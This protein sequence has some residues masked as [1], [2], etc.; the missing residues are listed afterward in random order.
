MTST[1]QEKNIE[2]STT[3]QLNKMESPFLSQNDK[4]KDDSEI[5]KSKIVTNTDAMVDTSLSSKETSDTA[6]KKKRIADT[7]LTK[8]DVDRDGDDECDSSEEQITRGFEKASEQVL[9]TRRLARASNRW[10]KASKPKGDAKKES[11]EVKEESNNKVESDKNAD[12]NTSDLKVD[13]GSVSTKANPFGS[14]SF[15]ASTSQLK[16]TLQVGTETTSVKDP[17]DKQNSN[18]FLSPPLLPVSTT[19]PFA[20]ATSKKNG[21]PTTDIKSNHV[22]DAKNGKSSDASLIPKTSIF[23]SASVT[24]D[25][26]G[27]NLGGKSL[28]GTSSG[29]FFGKGFAS[30]STD[31]DKTIFGSM[32]STPSNSKP[33]IFSKSLPSSST[34]SSGIVNTVTENTPSSSVQNDLKTNPDL[35]ENGNNPS[36]CSN[37]EENEE[38]MYQ[39]R[40]KLFK[41]INVSQ[42]LAKGNVASTSVSSTRG[43]PPTSYNKLDVSK[44]NESDGK[45][46]DGVENTEKIDKESK[47]NDKKWKEEGI[48]PLRILK[49]ITSPGRDTSTGEQKD[50]KSKENDIKDR[51]DKESIRIVQRREST[52]GGQGTKLILNIRLHSQ[53]N[54]SRQ[55]D[56]YVCLATLEA[57]DTVDTKAKSDDK[58]PFKS[59]QY[60]FKLKAKSDADGLQKSLELGLRQLNDK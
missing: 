26:N 55:S 32:S 30:P 47:R 37:G 49:T 57:T 20:E 58:S 23:G 28:F 39:T 48:G 34:P 29:S 14:I 8:D 60:L 42:N 33:S 54:I 31:N 4:N 38:C 9:S 52:P 25:S 35:S 21:L 59:V 12:I 5:S 17:C 18:P 40:A 1:D 22:D 56:N 19:N 6:C 51:K 41:L 50:E 7:Y 45:N 44:T 3:N 11:E 27:F 10:N 43:I 13:G 16:S 15:S 36:T 2:N 24:K 53:C 46:C